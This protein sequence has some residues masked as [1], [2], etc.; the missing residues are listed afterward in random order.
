MLK[1]GDTFKIETKL[2]GAFFQ[3]VR[4]I[5]PF[6]AL[7]RVLP[8]TFKKEPDS[9]ASLVAGATKF[10]TFFPVTATLKEK[11]VSEVETFEVPGHAKQMPIFRTGV[12][13]PIS[14]TVKKWWLWDGVREWEVGTLSDTE[15]KYPIRGVWNDTLL[16]ER[17][18]S[19]WLPEKDF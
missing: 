1:Q 11:R 18:E 8:G 7:I 17:I 5:P 6:G 9:I 16:I 19:D 15:K 3:Y 4:A 13:D 12:M 10:W 2:G 14:K